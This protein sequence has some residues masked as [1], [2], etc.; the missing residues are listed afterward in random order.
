MR[1]RA[2]TLAVAVVLALIAAIYVLRRQYPKDSLALV[3][4][5]EYSPTN[6]DPR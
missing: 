4:V 3:F 6:V 2:K 5:I 1:H